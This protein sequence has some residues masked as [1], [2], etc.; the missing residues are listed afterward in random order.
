MD[1]QLAWIYKI[2]DLRYMKLSLTSLQ[3]N[4]HPDGE[5]FDVS[6]ED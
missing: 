5:M 1:V 4:M 2:F 6:L 3:N